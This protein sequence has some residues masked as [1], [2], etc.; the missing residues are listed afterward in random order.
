MFS[1]RLATIL[2][3]ILFVLINIV[4]LSVSTKDS[5]RQTFVERLV[6][7]GIL[8]L[9]EG[10]TRTMRFCRDVWGE[11]FDLVGAREECQRLREKLARAEMER[12]RRLE[13]DLAYQRLRK[14][15]KMK[16]ELPYHVLSAQVVGL[17]PSGW[18]KTVIINRGTGDGVSKG[19][20][21]TATEG[22]VGHIIEAYNRYSKV[23]L[24]IDRNSA[25][26][27]LV[28]RTRSR[29]VVEGDA[30]DGCRM[31]YVVRKADIK[32]GDTVISS[33]L[34]G[35][36]PKGVPIG[37]ILEISVPTSGLFQEVRVRPFVDFTRLEE[38][39]VIMK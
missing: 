25:I 1:K 24:V 6:M 32:T 22:I 38:L 8:P 34:D 9:Q 2:C 12:G 36:F 15:L 17:D 16:S 30:D 35:L 31:K 3:V 39:L 20:A 26:D 10:V 4:L 5:H 28:Q 29:G 21:V 7:A 13:S 33:G 27:A 19:M 23:L 11:Y 14:L 18:F 37:E